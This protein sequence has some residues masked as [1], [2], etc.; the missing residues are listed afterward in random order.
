MGPKNE[1]LLKTYNRNLESISE[2]GFSPIVLIGKGI[3]WL[4]FW[5][6]SFINNF[7]WTII[8]FSL[9]LKFLLNPFTAKSMESAKK[10]QALQPQIAALK[11][12]YKN[13]S[14]ELNAK[15]WALYKQEKVSPAG[16]CLPMLLQMPFFFALYQVLPYIVELKNVHFLW[17]KDLSSP[18]TVMFIDIFKDIPVLPYRLNILPILMTIFSF[19]QTKVSHG[20][21]SNTGQGKMMELMM[22]LVFLF[23]FWNMPS[24]LVLYWLLQTVFTIVHQYIKNKQPNKK[25]SNK[26]KSVKLSHKK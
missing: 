11:E 14:Q 24:G 20:G 22:P 6:N 19:I 2:R 18:D 16:S 3:K 23:V 10:M 25:Q 8:L 5:L 26:K 15:I 17:I 21:Q 12:K 1:Q 13:K 9:L 7:A 4:L